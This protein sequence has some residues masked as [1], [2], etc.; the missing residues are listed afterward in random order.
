MLPIHI[1][2]ELKL[3]LIEIGFTD[4]KL[5]QINIFVAI[6][7]EA[8]HKVCKRLN[9]KNIGNIKNAEIV[10]GQMLDHT[11]YSLMNK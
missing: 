3:K 1:D 11:K 5:N 6:L 8:S 2:R 9:M 7:N 10:N 4:L